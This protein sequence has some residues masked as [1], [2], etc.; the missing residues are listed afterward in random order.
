MAWNSDRHLE[1]YFAVPCTG[2]VLHTLNHRL[3][4]EQIVYIVNHA[5][6]RAIFVDRSILDVLVPLL[7][8]LPTVRHLV[9]LDDVPGA[10]PLPGAIDGIAVHD[11]EALVAAHRPAQFVVE[12]ERQAASMCYTSGTTGNPKGVVYTHRSSYLHSVSQMTADALA[13][14][15]R[16]VVLPV[17]P[18]FHANAWGL[19]HAGAAVGAD[20]VLPGADHSGQAIARL[21]IEHGVTLTAGVPTIW[22]NALPYLAGTETSLRQILCGGSAVPKALSEAYRQQVGLPVTQAWGMTETSP[23]VAINT[24]TGAERAAAAEDQAELN[25]TVGRPSLGVKCRIVDPDSG[26]TLP[27]D[28]L[29][30]GELQC[31]GPWI[32]SGYHLDDTGSSTTADG[33]LRTGDVATISASGRIRL[34]D[35]TKDLIKSGGEWISSVEVENLLMAHPEIVEAAVIGVADERWGERPLAYVVLAPDATVDVEEIKAFLAADLAKW[36]IPD[37]YAFLAEIPKTSVGKFSKRALRELAATDQL[38][39]SS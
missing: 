37:R 16:D 13:V 23:V 12:D 18:M 19:A 21:I 15:E 27:E 33:W 7:V 4:A 11:Y 30:S 5:E 28:G 36:Q 34:V 25:T 38:A 8:E 39:G 22:T 9:V 35:R 20:I 6:D 26:E 14:S 32:A 31:W 24:M 17:V 2:R 10:P 29:A 1:L 3:F